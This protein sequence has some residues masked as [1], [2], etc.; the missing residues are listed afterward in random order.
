MPAKVATAAGGGGKQTCDAFPIFVN[1]RGYGYAVGH[2]THMVV[3]PIDSFQI[4]NT[5]L[6]AVC[7]GIFGWSWRPAGVG[8]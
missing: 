7:N 4:A 2:S 5:L 3:R 8:E 6:Y 1:G